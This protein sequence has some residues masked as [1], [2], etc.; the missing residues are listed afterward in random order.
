MNPQDKING[1]DILCEVEHLAA[2]IRVCK[3][4]LLSVKVKEPI[5]NS[6]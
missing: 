2:T 4:S 3:G 6:I 1:T 5:G